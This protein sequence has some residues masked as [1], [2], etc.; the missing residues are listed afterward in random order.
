MFSSFYIFSHH[1]KDSF[2]LF[3]PKKMFYIMDSSTTFH[4][5]LVL[6]LKC[7]QAMISKIY[8]RLSKMCTFHV[9]NKHRLQNAS[10]DEMGF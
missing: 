1:V 6:G 10:I 9:G 7:C 2:P 5:L 3:Q 8:R 4:H